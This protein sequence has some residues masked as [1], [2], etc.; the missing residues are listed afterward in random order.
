MASRRASLLVV[1]LGLWGSGEVMGFTAAPGAGRFAPRLRS[2]ASVDKSSSQLGVT[3]LQSSRR[4]K[5]GAIEM[6]AVTDG[7]DVLKDLGLK[8][9][10]RDQARLRFAPSPTGSLH[11][12]GA[13][14]ALYSY[15][16]AKKAGGKFVLRIEDTDLARSTK[17]SENS[18][19]QDL[20]WLGLDWDEGPYN[21]GPA[22]DYR[23]SERG[24]LYI[25]IAKKLAEMGWAYPCFCTEE[26]LDAK[27]KA[28]EESGSAVAYDGTW[29]DADPAEVKKRMDAGETF[30]YRFKVPK[31]KVVSIDDMVRGR[32]SWD[33]EATLGDFILLRSNGVPVYNF[34][35]AVDDALMGITTVARAEEHLT[36]TVRQFLVLE[37]LG[38]PIPQYAHCS[39]ILG[40]D[41]SKLSKR[42]GATSCDQF[43]QQGYLPDAMI[44]YLALLGWNDGTDKDI[45][46]REEL[47]ESFDLSRVTA[48]PAQF[49]QAKLKWINGQHLRAMQ[50]E[51]FVPHM[52][53]T[54]LRDGVIGKADATL[55]N[56]VAGMVQEKC[57]LLNDAA[58]ILS[59]CLDYELAETAK[60]CEEASGILGDDFAS[61]ASAIS[62]SV[63]KG[64]FPADMSADSFE[65]DFKDWINA[66][67]KTTGRKGK[68]LFMPVR[69]AL[70]G[71]LAGPDIG[72]QLKAVGLA[73]SAEPRKLVTLHQRM[74]MLTSFVD[75][76]PELLK[77]SAASAKGGGGSSGIPDERVAQKIIE[78]VAKLTVTQ[79][80]Q[81][82]STAEQLLAA[83]GGAAA[84]AAAKQ[85]GTPEGKVLD[86][87]GNVEPVTR[88]D[89]RVGKIL[90]CEKHPDAD[91]LY[92]EQIDV[93][94]A[95]PRTVISGLANF[96]PLEEMQGRMVAVVCNLKPA[97][98]RG[99][100]S[101][102]MVLCG[103]N[104]DHSKV[105]ILDPPTGAQPGEHLMLE[106]FGI[107]KPSPEDAVLKSKS[108]QGV[109]KMVAPDLKLVGGEAT[110]NGKLF[111]TSAGPLTTKNLKDGTVG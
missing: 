35:V 40:E 99:I 93:G 107:M 47:I 23:Q 15:L 72:L 70:T 44:N 7:V 53:E 5:L 16:A 60:T 110:Y 8:V 65:T 68:R 79:Q 89:I 28:A 9:V 27:R 77:A 90:S 1:S 94:E 42:H 48:S 4:A 103:S 101:S 31:G 104:E 100:M 38:F 18:M 49:D 80:R 34:C 105:E 33:V 14:T 30:T 11:V 97:K 63:S 51:T 29:R 36:N 17:E 92:L 78:T 81:V 19:I 69:L 109:W 21:G 13:R 59:S 108:Q 64:E 102:G 46:T 55:M 84:P 2:V 61:L 54:L 83:G 88:L 66:L 57:D 58:A 37:A 98:M 32:I 20:K 71:N 24:E 56:H 41:R 22:G 10:P 106:G 95:E 62:E 87:S 85:G 45:Y 96:V 74:A 6:T 3:R 82:L 25:T 12:G 75:E 91:A 39:L 86:R 50:K 52:E 43:R 73:A 111:T 76:N 67:G 26:E